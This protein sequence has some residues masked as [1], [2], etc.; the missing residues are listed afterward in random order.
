MLRLALG[1]MVCLG[2]GL[3]VSILLSDGADRQTPSVRQI[4]LAALSF[5]GA[6]IVLVG[7]LVREHGLTWSAAFGLEVARGRAFALGALAIC[8][9]VP[10]GAVLQKISLDLLE[11]F[12]IHPG[13]QSAVEALRSLRQGPGLWAFVAITV[14]VAP[15]GEELLF[16]GV[17]YPAIKQAGYPRLAAWGTS[18]L[19]A[20]IHFHLPIFLPLLLLA[21]LLVWLYE[22]TD[23]LLA[24]LAAHALFNA[25]NLVIFFA[26]GDAPAGLPAP[27]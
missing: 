24:P 25:A 8:L 15:L 17:L 14:V 1:L 13:H 2:V 4:V 23:N 18:A 7:W 26:R 20:A 22:V 10:V 16:R 9:F 5:Q 12:G 27:P 19:F 21:L 3:L 6:S 11:G